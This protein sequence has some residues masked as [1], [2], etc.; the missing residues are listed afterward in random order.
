M[1][2]IFNNNL[3][4]AFLFQA[5][6]RTRLPSPNDQGMYHCIYYR[7]AINIIR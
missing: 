6:L 2:N 5:S 7:D 4:V 1:E 3:N